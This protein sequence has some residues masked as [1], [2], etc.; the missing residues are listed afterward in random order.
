MV[1]KKRPS[2]AMER[3]LKM[4]YEGWELRLDCRP[5][6]PKALLVKDTAEE[7]VTAATFEALMS[8]QYVVQDGWAGTRVAKF[9]MRAGLRLDF[10]DIAA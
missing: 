9:R 1:Q 10:M 6:S 8:R 5:D 7:N 3:V 2:P 4:M